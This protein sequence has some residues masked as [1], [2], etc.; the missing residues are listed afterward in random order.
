VI[1]KESDFAKRSK[2]SSSNTTSRNYSHT[3]EIYCI[4][5]VGAVVLHKCCRSTIQKK[6]NTTKR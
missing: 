6:S 4:I 2:T 1:A 5:V 3:H